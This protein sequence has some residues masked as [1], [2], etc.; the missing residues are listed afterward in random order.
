MT[1][2]DLVPS[3]GKGR[4]RSPARRRDDDPFQEFQR[5]MNRLFDDFFGEFDRPGRGRFG[6]LPSRRESGT[7][8]TGLEFSPRV[9]VSETDDTVEVTA[10]LPGVDEKDVTVEMDDSSVTVRGEKKEEREQKG[11]NWFRREQ[12]YGTFQ[13]VIP[14][15][16]SVDREK[17]K[18]KFR[19]GVLSISL[20]KREEDRPSR[21]TIDIETD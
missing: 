20:P 17:A 4:E 15:P 16:A 7:E 10:E 11:K 14:L 6:L 18:A 9:D 12:S 3:F 13:R 19:K 2:K 1:I 5:E 8:W 21:R